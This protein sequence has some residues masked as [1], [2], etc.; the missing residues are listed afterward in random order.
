MKK[1][2]EELM[3][4]MGESGYRRLPA[5]R[6]SSKE[7]WLF[8]TDYP[9][10]ADNQSVQRL[11][12]MLREVGWKAE[13]D[14]GWVFI[15]RFPVYEASEEQP[16]RTPEACCCLSLIKRNLNKMPSDGSIERKIL[17]ALEEGKDAYDRICTD[18]HAQ[19]AALL[20]QHKDLPDIDQR[21]FGG[22]ELKC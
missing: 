7:M 8:A 2:R 12:D 13:L 3:Q 18:V 17:K 5:L 16:F 4:L 15:D 1:W 19:W 22:E 10:A 20:R 6:R 21:F 11:L 9:Q 14:A